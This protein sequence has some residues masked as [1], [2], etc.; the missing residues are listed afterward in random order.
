MRLNASVIPDAPGHR[1]LAR[2]T[3]FN[4]SG[5][6]VPVLVQLVTVPLYI[7]MIG[8]DRYGVMALVWLLLGYF[9][10][11]DLGFGRAIASRIAGLNAGSV[12]ARA[13]VFW[14]GTLLSVLAGVA[15][16]LLL[17]AISFRLFGNVFAVPPYLRAETIAALPCIALALPVVTGISALAGALQGREEFGVMNFSQM[18]GSILY[19]IFPLLAA[20]T[21]SAHLSC[22][23]LAA[24]AGRLVTAVM[25]FVF[26]MKR[27]PAGRPVIARGEIR[28]LLA[29]GGWVTLSGLVS[30]LLTVFD[31][32]VVGALTGM[33]AVTAYTIPYNLVMRI[34]ALPTSLQNALFPRFAM[35]EE[36]PARALQ[37]Q[38]TVL[39]ACLMT[40][41]L[42]I[43]VLA[44]KAFL[45]LW[46]GPR[47]AATA[48][49]VGQILILGLWPNMLAFIP[50]GYLQSRGRPDLPAKFHVGELVFY[51]PALYFL[52]LRYGL[53]GAAWAWDARTLADAVLLFAAVGWLPGLLR[54]WPGFALLVLAFAWA[55]AAPGGAAAYSAF[56]TL[57]VA[58]SL[59]WALWGL[60]RGMW[61]QL[62][63]SR[64][65]DA[66]M[67]ATQ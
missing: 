11:F 37:Q 51:A 44:M 14:T 23:V 28:P 2:A 19:Q 16:G 25:L 10:F 33:T 13:A 15:G 45:T 35:V 6:M 3:M 27:I 38:A 47:L 42:L 34:A 1:G 65:Q 64:R 62:L 20:I 29:F 21:I 48:A 67:S 41:P 55:Q 54:G 66:R 46:I 36:A 32:F 30:P 50:F 53:A 60:P 56:G 49:P 61:R 9:G 58:A 8:T 40:P 52:T 17:Y 7:K 5:L 22:L 43:G 24:L 26:C 18:T 57:L 59:L 39:I 12:A 4:L 63:P 31:R